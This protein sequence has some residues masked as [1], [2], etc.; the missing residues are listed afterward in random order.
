MEDETKVTLMNALK[1]TYQ[2]MIEQRGISGAALKEFIDPLLSGV[3]DEDRRV[4]SDKLYYEHVR[5]VQD[6]QA[7]RG[8]SY[9]GL[10]W[11]LRPWVSGS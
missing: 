5:Q 9:L 3:S 1:A 10:A 8:Y 2:G 6:N 7:E 4:L 11:Y